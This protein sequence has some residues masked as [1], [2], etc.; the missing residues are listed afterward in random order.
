MKSGLCGLFFSPCP[1]AVAGEQ[2]D[3]AGQS[4]KRNRVVEKLVDDA[5]L[6]RRRHGL[7]LRLGCLS[8][9]LGRLRRGFGGFGYRFWCLGHRLGRF[10]RRFRCLR[11]GLWGCGGGHRDYWSGFRLRSFLQ[12]GQLLVLHFQQLL[13][14][15]DV[16]FQVGDTGL[17]FFHC[18][19][20]GNRVVLARRPAGR[21]GRL[22][23]V[24][25]GKPYLILWRCGRRF[26]FRLD[27]ALGFTPAA[28]RFDGRRR[29]RET[30][31][32]RGE[33]VHV[34]LHQ[35]LRFF[36]IDRTDGFR[37]RDVEDPPRAQQ[38]DVLADEC[39][40][41]GA[42]DR[43]QHLV[44]VRARRQ[45]LACNFAQR[46][47]LLDRDLSL[48][49]GSRLADWLRR[50]LFCFRRGGFLD[51][52]LGCRRGRQCWLDRGSRD[53]RQRPGFYRCRCRRACRFRRGLRCR[54]FAGWLRLGGRGR[55]GG[56]HGRSPNCLRR[57]VFR[58]V[59]KNRV[60]AYQPAGGPL[61]LDQHLEE[62]I[63]NRLSGSH[64]QQRTAAAAL[65]REPRRDERRIEVDARRLERVGGSQTR[66]QT[67][68]LAR[69]QGDDL[70]L[71]I[72][73]LAERRNHAQLAQPGRMDHRT[74]Q[75]KRGR[76][77]RNG[78]RS[79]HCSPPLDRYSKRPIKITSWS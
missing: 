51:L 7:G 57:P 16:L 34:R 39:I 5:R 61:Q 20:A 25:L 74:R 73:R 48:F 76:N 55:L 13:Q 12:F 72:E 40:L 77:H 19:F 53:G 38:V 2:H 10:C 64:A 22:A 8:W 66:H 29:R 4:G 14:I 68:F 1:Y 67:F 17:R 49:R 70:D 59:E 79:A 50:G 30:A 23:R 75:P 24:G 18:A 27:L 63:V 45:V 69:L 54:R 43:N 44:E 42:V 41:V 32:V 37:A 26:R 3:H 78:Y 6:G 60:L 11:R 35:A 62:R 47:A 28:R 36:R 31:A 33:V 71:G 15:G 9:R 52:R 65:E 58:W 56:R 46:V 21:R